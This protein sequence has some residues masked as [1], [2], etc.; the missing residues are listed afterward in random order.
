M[1]NTT[2]K[3]PGWRN[4]VGGQILRTQ[5]AITSIGELLGWEF[6]IY[7]PLVHLGFAR[8]ARRNAPPLAAAV[9]QRF[10]QLIRMV[11]VGCGTGGFMDH[12][13]NAG[14]DVVG[15]EY[16]AT[17]RKRCERLGLKVYPFDL[18]QKTVP[19]P[20]CPF[21]LALSTEVAEHI[22]AQYADAMVDY[23]SGLSSTIVFTA[24]Q[25]GQGGTGHINEQPRSYWIEKFTRR[26]LKLDEAST[27]FIHEQLKQSPAFPFLYNNL[28]VFVR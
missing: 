9:R 17:L 8:A 4:F 16:S 12:F 27:L 10:P 23:I 1:T 25:P 11:D 15:V 6:L 21:D 5:R 19:P 26:G 22:P 7:N 24:A 28:S 18:S 13:R 20:G 2:S 14:F 3:N